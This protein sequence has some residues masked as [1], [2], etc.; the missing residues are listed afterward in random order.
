MPAVGTGSG[1]Q[2]QVEQIEKKKRYTDKYVMVDAS[3]PELAFQ[4]HRR[5]GED[6]EHERPGVGGLWI[7]I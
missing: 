4:G 1:F 2:M 6:R 7:T 5:P 3:R